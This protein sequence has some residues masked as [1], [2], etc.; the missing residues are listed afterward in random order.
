MSCIGSRNERG[1]GGFPRNGV[2]FFAALRLAGNMAAIR[3]TK[4]SPATL[5]RGGIRIPIAPAISK[6]PV[7]KTICL[8]KGN[9]GGTMLI[10]S[11][12][13]FVKCAE[14]VNKNINANAKRAESW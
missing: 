1:V 7:M 2:L 9:T 4:Q 13:I 5:F 12:F 10:R 6:I 14:A 3:I 11:S 8:G